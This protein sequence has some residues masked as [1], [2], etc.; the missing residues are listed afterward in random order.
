MEQRIIR[1]RSTIPEGCR[2]CREWPL[3]W[4]MTETCPE[5]PT[6]CVNCGR[7]FSGLV[8]VYVGVDLDAI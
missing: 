8:R 6:G 2:V 7:R 4:I 1:L 3:V 5:P